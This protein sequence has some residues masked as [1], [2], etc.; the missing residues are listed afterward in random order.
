[1]S[2]VTLVL[3]LWIC[4]IAVCLTVVFVV[5]G[6]FS[7]DG[8]RWTPRIWTTKCVAQPLPSPPSPPG[9]GAPTQ[10]GRAASP[11]TKM[12]HRMATKSSS[13]FSEYVMQAMKCPKP[14]TKVRWVTCQGTT[15]SCGVQLAETS[16]LKCL[17]VAAWLLQPLKWPNCCFLPQ[18]LVRWKNTIYPWLCR[19]LGKWW[20][21]WKS[22]PLWNVL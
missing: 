22:P 13:S 9:S 21:Q 18:V 17:T 5:L 15:S 7:V 20:W 12:G 16:S 2:V 1:M 11:F 19:A 8:S 14:L 3:C 4:L 10:V 6:I